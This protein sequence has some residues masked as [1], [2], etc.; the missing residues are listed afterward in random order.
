M[1]CLHARPQSNKF[2]AGRC[3]LISAVSLQGI[4][5]ERLLELNEAL[6]GLRNEIDHC[7]HVSLWCRPV[8]KPKLA[9]IECHQCEVTQTQNNFTATLTWSV[10]SCTHGCSL[11]LSSD[12]GTQLSCNKNRFLP[13]EHGELICSVTGKFIDAGLYTPQVHVTLINE[14]ADYLRVTGTRELSWEKEAIATACEDFSTS[15]QVM[16]S[17]PLLTIPFYVSVPATDRTYSRTVNGDNC[18]YSELPTYYMCSYTQYCDSQ[19][20]WQPPST[21]CICYESGG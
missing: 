16:G 1:H 4:S 11:L 17:V 8:E 3:L 10:R 9:F 5:G 19:G 20:S 12:Q 6:V 15:L 18:R 13:R 2:E 7:I 21:S 14:K